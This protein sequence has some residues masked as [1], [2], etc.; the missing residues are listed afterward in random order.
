MTR[1][2]LLVSSLAAAT[3]PKALPAAA[4][5]NPD[6]LV[7]FVD[8]LPIPPI[9]K[10]AGTRPAPG[11]A[12]SK[13]P[14]YRV[15]MRQQEQKLH[16]DLPPTRLWCYGGSSPGPTFETRRGQGLLVEWVNELPERHYLP[17]DHTLDGAEAAKPEVR[18]V[19][20]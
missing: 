12:S 7:K 8:P 16:R 13:V 5:L 3:A 1:R 17:I 19:V 20:H 2:T 10:P 11:T 14:Y 18:G 9:A 4:A 15:A 6:S